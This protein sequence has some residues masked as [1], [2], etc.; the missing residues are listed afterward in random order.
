M[1]LS[2]DSETGNKRKFEHSF[3]PNISWELTAKKMK[4]GNSHEEPIQTSENR[5]VSISDFL[6]KKFD[7]HNSGATAA[8][9]LF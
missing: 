1:E 4:K 9:T 6:S 5:K 3:V 2:D 7:E 8:A